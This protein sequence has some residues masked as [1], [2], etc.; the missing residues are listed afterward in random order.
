MEKLKF[1]RY[2]LACMAAFIG[3]ALCSLSIP[4]SLVAMGK[5]L[6]FPLDRGGMAAGGVLH[7]TRSVAIV[8][9]LMVCG[10]IAGRIGKRKSMGLCTLLMGGGILLCALAPDYWF[11]LPFLLIAGFGEGIC[12]GIATPF[13]QDL[14]SDA[15][16]RYVNITHS[17]WSVGIG[18]CVLGAGGLLS[19]GVSWRIV[20]AAAGGLTMLASIL[21][22]WKEDPHKKYPDI[23]TVSDPAE[24]WRLSAAIFRTPRFWLHCLAMFMGAGAEYCLTFWSA[25]YLQL[26]FEATAWMVG[27][28]TAAVGLGMFIG[29]NFFGLIAREDNLRRNLIFAAAGTIP[30]I[31]IL[32]FVTPEII[33]SRT[34][35]F[36]L[37][38]AV[39]VCCGIGIAPFWPTMQVYSVRQLPELDTTMMYIYLSAVGIPGCG[40]FTWIV[41]VLGDRFGLRGAFVLLPAT[42]ICYILILLFDGRHYRKKAN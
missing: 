32:S 16:E 22:L 20:L 26:T 27:L 29:R 34:L 9:A 38:L 8:A 10:L 7:L 28:G 15:P 39:L 37:L 6:N 31:L 1:G 23:R 40:F 25:A 42:L 35:L 24:L 2:D 4:V 11:L 33:P 17:Y 12:E 41:G 18:I 5:S 21:F 13:V 14:H 36:I 19:R 3:Y 30:L